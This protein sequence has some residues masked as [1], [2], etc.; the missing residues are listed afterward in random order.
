MPSDLLTTM[1]RKELQVVES[2]SWTEAT[3]VAEDNSNGEDALSSKVAMQGDGG[4]REELLGR[5]T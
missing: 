5:A 3:Q 4:A 2:P 1:S